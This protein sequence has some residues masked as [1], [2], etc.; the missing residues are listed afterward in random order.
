MSAPR[1]WTQTKVVGTARA[2][3]DGYDRVSGR[4]VYARD[5]VLPGMLYAAFARCPHAHARVEKVDTRRAEA[6]PG[7]LAVLTGDSPGARLPF[8]FGEKGPLSW[9]FDPHCRFEGEEVAAVAAE[10]QA[11][12]EA[13]ARAIAVEYQTLPFV[14]DME[15]ALKPGAPEIHPGGNRAGEP[16]RYQRGDVAKGFAEAAAVVEMTFRT[17][18][19]IH[20]PM[21]THGSLAQWDGDRLTIWDTNQGVFDL[22]SAYAQFFQLPLSQVR[23]VSA[24]MGGGFGSKLEPG[25]YTLAAALLARQTG[26][27]VRLFLS[28]E[29]T[30]LCVGNR[31]PNV[32]TLKAGAGKDGTLTALQLTGIGTGGAYPE[33]STAGYLVSDLYTCPNV[34]V[35][36]TSAY[37]NAGKA[38]AF[39]APGFPQGA[40][41]LEQTMDA[42]ARKLG[43]D[44]LALRLKNVP[45]V[46]QRRDNLPYTSTGLRQCL[47]DG[48]KAFGWTEA[49]RRPRAR[50]PIVRGIG[51]AAGMW[52]WDGEAKGS[53]IVRFIADGSVSLTTGAADIGTGTKTVL[54]MVVSEELG[55]PLEKIQVDHADTAT[56][57][58]AV[59][60][61]GSQTTHI[62]AP[63]VRAAALDVKQQLVAMAA[64]QMKLEPGALEL[65]DGVIV[66][67]ASPDKKVALKDLAGLQ[68]QQVIVGVGRREAHPKGKVALP[69][70]VHF[71]EVEVDTR[72]GEVRVLRLLGAH[73][74]G[75]VMSRLSYENQVFGGM[76][77]CLGFGMTE[78]R[79]L[80]RNTG[81][82]TNANWHDYKIPTAKDV[83]AEPVCLPV[84]PH[85]TECNSVGAKGLGEPATIPTAAAIANA[86]F[87]ATG[88]RV[89]ETPINP[90]Q[91]AR[92]LAGRRAGS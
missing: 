48:A 52:G 41:A 2:R 45:T 57:P 54:A 27:P 24:Y 83:P 69:F 25:K 4:A 80:D 78:G 19:V 90:T 61:G 14:V 67:T 15:Q 53:A 84:D 7:V 6:M 22:R 21:E 60:S 49:Q 91:M 42:L 30:F 16:D 32:L 26:R 76:T 62:N 64:E 43:M 10:T 13:A 79:V 75:R 1:P 58:Y 55:V 88:V 29:E 74:S 46:S 9:L 72:T 40:W 92:L 38:R 44:P 70:V 65:Q 85:D 36:E 5:L 8:Y 39:R 17:P 59:L 11:Q 37:V 51:V 82:M 3:I 87:D 77:M 47:E 63:I 23:V 68:D 89:T 34:K 28:R 35:E 71:A 81:K 33:G 86:V 66:A 73:D 20:T 50:G 12:A 56:T 31:P 18:C